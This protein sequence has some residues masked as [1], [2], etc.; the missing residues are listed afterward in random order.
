MNTCRLLVLPTVILSIDVFWRHC[1]HER[2]CKSLQMLDTVY[3][4]ALRLITGCKP[5]AHHCI[6]YSMVN[7]SS[8]SIHWL[9]HWSNL[10]YKSILSL[11]PTY[12]PFSKSCE[13][14]GQ[15][16][17]SQSFVTLM[18]SVLMEL[19]NKAFSYSDPLVWNRLQED[20]KLCSLSPIKDFKR[21]LFSYSWYVLVLTLNPCT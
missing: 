8:L 1:Q 16:R 11:L 15:C 14:S 18:C 21:G 19:D 12:L 9:F 20:L 7:W 13:Q 4:T 6:S 3:H 17:R 5:F 2:L 10:T